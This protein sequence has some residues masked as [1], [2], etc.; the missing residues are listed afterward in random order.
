MARAKGKSRPAT[1]PRRLTRQGLR[2]AYAQFSNLPLEVVRL[3][4]VAAA[5]D[6]VASNP[7]WVAQSLALVCREFCRAV[8]P[9]LVDTLCITV[10]NSALILKGQ[11]RFLRTRRLLLYFRLR[12]TPL[13]VYY[14][15][16]NFG[17]HPTVVTVRMED[18]TVPSIS[19][20][21]AAGE[22]GATHLHIRLCHV[23][24][25]NSLSLFMS[26][27]ATH[28]VTHLILDAVI[29]GDTTASIVDSIADLL[30][31]RPPLH[32]LLVRSVGVEDH[33]R[34]RFIESLAQLGDARI[35]LDDTIAYSHEDADPDQIAQ[36]EYQDIALWYT[37]RQ[38]LPT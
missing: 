15:A 25:L 36:D 8:E 35:W 9:G 33:F 31:V 38:L 10:S 16:R 12:T 6:N 29:Q 30:R 4:A 17:F 3:I 28:P 27:S 23:E 7:K 13:C 22:T 20:H 18:R 24:S 2:D 26:A 21:L 14:M 5:Q 11:H 19:Q 1:T 32:R 34:H 37:G